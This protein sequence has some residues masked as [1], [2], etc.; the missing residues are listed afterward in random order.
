VP[1][2]AFASAAAALLAAGLWL[3]GCSSGPAGE[4]D[5]DPD[6]AA[7]IQA[8]AAPGAGSR[9]PDQAS[10]TTPAPVDLPFARYFAIARQ[11]EQAA[12]D[13]WYAERAPVYQENQDKTARCMREQGFDWFPSPLVKPEPEVPAGDT[14]PFPAL[15]AERAEA[16]AYGYGRWAASGGEETPT[17]AGAKLNAYLDALGE[18][19]MR[20]F[21]RALLED[22]ACGQDLAEDFYSA[23]AATAWYTEPVQ[24]MAAA[25]AGGAAA[26]GLMGAEGMEQ[27]NAEWGDCMAKAGALAAGQWRADPDRPGPANA[28]DAAVAAGGLDPAE[29]AGLPSQIG[30]GLADFDC[31]RQTDYLGRFAAIQLQFETAWVAGHRD[32][33]DSF[34]A[35]AESHRH[36]P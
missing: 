17:D 32:L 27:L 35:A 22:P 13:R 19:G 25:L 1:R 4:V 15:P 33:L 6:P 28:F 11:A 26:G 31:R 9:D 29:L 21:Y 34:E 36:Q 5:P 16:A 20:A 14:L 10:L 7:A 3:A 18:E 8:S 30:I 23:D 2:P 24:A 12:I